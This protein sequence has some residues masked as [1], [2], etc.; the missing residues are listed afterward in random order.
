VWDIIKVLKQS[1]IKGTSLPA[2]GGGDWDDTLQPAN[3]TLTKQ[4]VSAWTIALLYEALQH[5][6]RWPIFADARQ[7]ELA[8]FKDLLKKDFETYLLVD[9]VPAGFVIFYPDHRE[10][11]LHPQDKKTGLQYRLLPFN[12]GMIS[13]LFDQKNLDK[14][15]SIIRQHLKHPD[16]VRLMNTA[17][18]YQ[19]GKKTYF[20]RAET[21]A[22]FGREI[23]IQYVHA[24]IRYIEAMTTIGN[25]EEAWWG[26]NVINPIGIQSFVPN[27]E[28][29]Q[30]NVYFSSS[31]AAF[32]DRYEAK[33]D[34]EKV[35]K[36]TIK[37]KAGWRLYSSGPGIYLRTLIHHFLGIKVEQNNLV[38]DPMIPS[39]LKGLTI[40]YQFKGKP[41]KVMIQDLQ[42]KKKTTN[43]YRLSS[44]YKVES[45]STGLNVIL[46]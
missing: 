4:M 30:R 32:L 26:L 11:L 12:R 42:K 29:R 6:T 18:T 40:Q 31:D 3:Q 14:Y 22:N 27:A 28:R 19:G 17:V 46:K 7:T 44:E 34:F 20:Q 33:R 9:G 25:T 35:R 43:P 23:G 39:S 15:Q 13:Q 10:V 2:Y 1:A 38:I 16:G 21:A 8:Q 45:N 24:H 5:L 37:V 36:G 41:L